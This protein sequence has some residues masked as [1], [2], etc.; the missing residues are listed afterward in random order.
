MPPCSGPCP[1][2]GAHQ[3]VVQG[4]TAPPRALH[5]KTPCKK[6]LRWDR[7]VLRSCSRCVVTD[8]DVTRR[9]RSAPRPRDVIGGGPRR[10]TWALT[11]WWGRRAGRRQ[12]RV[13]GAAGLGPSAAAGSRRGRGRGG[14]EHGAAPSAALAVSC[15]SAAACGGREGRSSGAACLPGAGLRPGG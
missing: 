13:M 15:L 11:S 12:V 9:C 5:H 14:P 2:H 3:H 6:Q 1:R 10:R 7:G 8:R 4:S